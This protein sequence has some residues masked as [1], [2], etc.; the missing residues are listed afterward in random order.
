MSLIGSLF[1]MLVVSWFPLAMESLLSLPVAVTLCINIFFL[2]QALILP[3]ACYLSILKGRVTRFQVNLL[4][5]ADKKHKHICIISC[6][7]YILWLLQWFLIRF[8]FSYLQTI[9]CIIIITVGVV[10]SVFGTYSAV[11]KIVENLSSWSFQGHYFSGTVRD[12]VILYSVFLRVSYSLIV[13]ISNFEL[14]VINYVS[15]IPVLKF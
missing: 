3:C 8:C 5:F 7:I 14:H 1:T 6:W 13:W 11:T 15:P 9:L 2:L 4:R 10:A 12:T